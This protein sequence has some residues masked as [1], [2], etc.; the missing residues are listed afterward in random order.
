MT[1]TQSCVYVEVFT[2][3]K[4][5][6]EE[7]KSDTKLSQTADPFEM[8]DD[9]SSQSDDTECE[10]AVKQSRHTTKASSKLRK[11]SQ[12]RLNNVLFFSL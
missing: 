6:S 10:P 4:S 8:S 9:S 11:S 7:T 3:R 5:V 12:V 2:Y 1:I